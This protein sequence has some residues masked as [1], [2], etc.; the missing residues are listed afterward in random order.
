[1][2]CRQTLEYCTPDQNNQAGDLQVPVTLVNLTQRIK[3]SDPFSPDAY[4]GPPVSKTQFEGSHSI[5]FYNGDFG[6]QPADDVQ[7]TKSKFHR[8][9]CS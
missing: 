6:I 1:V 5:I 8:W 9:L 7:I 2:P 3:V 4:Q